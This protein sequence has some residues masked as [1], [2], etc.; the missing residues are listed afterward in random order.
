MLIK[1]IANYSHSTYITHSTAHVSLDAALF[2][3]QTH[4][5]IMN[6]EAMLPNKTPLQH[7]SLW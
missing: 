4:T 6:N 1:F 7:P 3:F 5:Q 2:H